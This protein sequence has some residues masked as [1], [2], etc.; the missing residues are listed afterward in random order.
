MNSYFANTAN[1]DVIQ[2]PVSFKPSEK[3]LNTASPIIDGLPFLSFREQRLGVCP[4]DLNN[5]F[6]SILASNK[7]PQVLAAV[8]SITYHVLWAKLTVGES[9]LT[10]NTAGYS[11]IGK[12]CSRDI[13]NYREFMLGIC[14]KVELITEVVFYSPGCVWFYSPSS[15]GIRR[16]FLGSIRPRFQISAVNSYAFTKVREGIIKA[17]G[18]ATHDILDHHNISRLRQFT[19]KARV[20]ELARDT[21]WAGDTT[22]YSNIGVILQCSNKACEAGKSKVSHSNICFPEDFN[23]ISWSTSTSFQIG[24]Q[25]IIGYRVENGVKLSNDWY[26]RLDKLILFINNISSHGVG[27]TS[28][29]K[30]ASLLASTLN[31]QFY[32]GGGGSRTRNTR[33]LSPLLFRLSYPPPL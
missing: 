13:G 23:R 1:G 11:D 29:T 31:I 27:Q 24:K 32:G 4:I 3:T 15:I 30:G 22:G 16:R 18:E 8:A 19:Q 12:A 17:S 10:K 14:Q 33:I 9:S 7:L 25:S 6:G 2:S 26:G 20:G 5:W 21:L 28:V